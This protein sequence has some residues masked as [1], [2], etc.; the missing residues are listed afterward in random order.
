MTA[1]AGSGEWRRRERSWRAVAAAVALARENGLRVEEP[2]VLNDLFS[3]M[4]HLRPAPVVARVATLMPRLRAPIADWLDLEIAV[5]TFLSDRGAPVV[6]PSRELPAGPHE[7]DGFAI[8]FWTYVEPDPDRTPTAADCSAMLPDLHD[9]LRSYPGE[10][11]ALCANDIPRGLEMLDRGAT[12]LS[13]T[14]VDLLRTSAE[15]LRPLWEAPGE[16]AQPLHGDAH[17]GNLISTR[18]GGLLWIDFEDVCLGPVEWDLATI[19]DPGAVAAHHRPDPEVLARCTELRA[20][21]VALC[22]IAFRGDFG[23][24]K[25]WDEGIR[26]MLGML[27]EAS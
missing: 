22:L 12:G 17:P 11:P 10:L 9:A 18:D 24:I 16:E 15:R 6:A 14:D 1:P 23:D 20:L 4:V 8:S 21:Q 7:R 19:M 13:G 26:S 25:G 5:T 2:T 3:L 27:A